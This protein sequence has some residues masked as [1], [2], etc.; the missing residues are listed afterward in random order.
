MAPRL[1]IV[2]SFGSKKGTQI[3]YPF[4]SKSPGKRFP[5]RFPNGALMETDTRLQGIFRSVLIYLFFPSLR[6]PGK[7]AP[8]MLP[9]RVP[10]DRDTPSPEPLVYSFIHSFMYVFRSPQKEALLHM[11]NS[12]KSP[13]TGRIEK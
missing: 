7:G 4:H 1:K 11:G 13:S 5:T 10:M 12:I 2:M 6:V 9:I 3:Y 8:S